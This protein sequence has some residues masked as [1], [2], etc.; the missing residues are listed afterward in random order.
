MRDTT[1]DYRD[2]TTNSLESEINGLQQQII[3]LRQE[4]QTLYSIVDVLRAKKRVCTH[5][6]GLGK[7]Y[8]AIVGQYAACEACKGAGL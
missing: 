3:A 6:S 8:N 7:V 1:D 5:C 4:I 2:M